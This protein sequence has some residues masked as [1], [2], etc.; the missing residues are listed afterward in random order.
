MGRTGDEKRNILWDG[1]KLLLFHSNRYDSESRL[2]YKLRSRAVASAC[3]LI[4]ITTVDG[5]LLR[6]TT[7][8][9]WVSLAGDKLSLE[10]K[11]T[12]K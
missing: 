6:G 10:L 8:I 1:L 3:A 12:W 11:K 9:F 4:V 5:A 7:F 2:T